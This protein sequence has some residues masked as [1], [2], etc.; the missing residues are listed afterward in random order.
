M[1]ASLIDKAIRRIQRFLD[2]AF[3]IAR[4]PAAW[5]VYRNG[6]ALS[7]H[8]SLDKQWFRALN[9]STVLDIGANVGQFA[10]TIRSILPEARI[11]AFEP[12]PECFGTLQRNFGHDSRFK[13]LNLALGEHDAELPFQ[14]NDY[15]PS[16]S[17]LNASVAHT[18]EFPFTK[19]TEHLNVI[20]RRLDDVAEQLAIVDPVLIKIDVQGYENQVLT[21]GEKTIRRAQM[22][23]I[24]TS[25]TTLYE[26]QFLFDA[27]YR[28][29]T[30]WGFV[31]SG[32]L[33]Q[34]YSFQSGKILQQDCIFFRSA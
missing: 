8:A 25:F 27:L 34:L 26:D 7:T 21:G 14:V 16:S 33:E 23:I 19:D 31:Y 5:S 13:A 1:S 4:V 9:I 6:G 2:T 22:V 18:T 12:V 32:S 30:G 10:L 11:Y 20:V 3:Y 15:P 28:K 24:E 17:F 29:L